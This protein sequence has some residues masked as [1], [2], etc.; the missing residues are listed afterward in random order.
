M[1]YQ[2]APMIRIWTAPPS[3][4]NRAKTV[5]GGALD[6]CVLAGTLTACALGG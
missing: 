6:W 1:V 5:F 4:T 2:I 3:P